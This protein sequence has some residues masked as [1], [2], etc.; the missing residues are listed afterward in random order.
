MKLGTLVAAKPGIFHACEL[1]SP[2]IVLSTIEF[3]QMSHVK[4]APDTVLRSCNTTLA[5]CSKPLLVTNTRLRNRVDRSLIL[6]SAI[7]TVRDE[8]AR[9]CT[10][11]TP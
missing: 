7:S 6:I 8:H 2:Q 9:E 1:F 3:C 5:A 4:C 11:E 10:L